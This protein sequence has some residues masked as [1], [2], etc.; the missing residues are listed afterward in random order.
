MENISAWLVMQ[1]V[2]TSVLTSRLTPLGHILGSC[3]GIDA[4]LAEIFSI[5]SPFD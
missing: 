1:V 3:K 2:M 5:L 4:D